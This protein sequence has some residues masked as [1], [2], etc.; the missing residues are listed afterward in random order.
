MAF[1]TEIPFL[2]RAGKRE[3]GNTLGPFVDQQLAASEFRDKFVANLKDTN[4]VFPAKKYGAFQEKLDLTRN[5]G[6]GQLIPKTGK[7]P[8]SISG[9]DYLNTFLANYDKSNVVPMEERVNAQGLGAFAAQPAQP[10]QKFPGSEGTAI[11]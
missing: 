10:P 4:P 9:P 6:T 1:K 3:A 8:F 11:S 2:L 7:D 5:S